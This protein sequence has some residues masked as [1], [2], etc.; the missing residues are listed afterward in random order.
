MMYL[1]LSYLQKTAVTWLALAP[2]VYVMT[3]MWWIPDGVK[4]APGVVLVSLLVLGVGRSLCPEI[5][6]DR[7]L[8]PLRSFINLLWLYIAYS[9]VIYFVHGGSWRELRA[10]L[11]VA[12]YLQFTRGL[13]LSES[14]RHG[15]LTLSALTLTAL[16]FYEY[17]EHGGRVGGNI[18]PI[19]FA[20]VVGVLFLALYSL[21][22]FADKAIKFR[23]LSV[24]L[25]IALL[26]A[27]MMTQTRGVLVPALGLVIVLLFLASLK[28]SG[29]RFSQAS[30]ALLTTLLIAGLGLGILNSDRMAQTIY[31]VEAVADGNFS[32]SIGVRL[33]L[34]AS[35]IPLIADAPIIG[36]GEHYREALEVLYEQG[37]LSSG[38]YHFNALHFHNQF[39]DT[40]VKKG[41][42]G[43]CL[44][45]AL[46]VVAIRA[47]WSSGVELWARIAGVSILILLIASAL[48]DVPLAHAPVIFYVGFML[49]ILAAEKP[50][51]TP[52][53]KQ[54]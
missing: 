31:E 40:W 10:F 19:P 8:S 28:Q 34:W 37:E 7:D 43:L 53:N 21:A 17:F 5:A 24:A 32:T 23:M 14:W 6:R 27:L 18:N 49:F 36:H 30:V 52:T 1:P 39:L 42:V 25:V 54:D 41:A 13:I 45:V 16:A 3:L 50:K 2:V 35:A 26:A 20:T 4:Y 33:K 9:A 46:I 47:F 12:L 15:L 29:V 38:L 44:L 48:T 51:T 22:L 11:C